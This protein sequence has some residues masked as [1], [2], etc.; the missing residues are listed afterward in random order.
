ML[1]QK[2][3]RGLGIGYKSMELIETHALEHGYSKTCL[4]TVDRDKF[5][6]LR[7]K[8]YH[9]IKLFLSKFNYSIV[10]KLKAE[11]LWEQI[12]TKCEIKNTLSFYVKNLV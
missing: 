1:L 6:P 7:P 10:D 5:H 9:D 3:F 11:I 12:D 8:N 4:C 2:E